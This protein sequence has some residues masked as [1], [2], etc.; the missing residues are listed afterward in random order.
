MTIEIKFRITDPGIFWS[1]QT[2]D[3]LGDYTL[4]APHIEEINDTY[5]DSKKRK[6]LA[7]GYRCRRREQGKG[8]L[9]TLTKLGLGKGA[10]K[11][12]QKWEVSLKKNKNNPANWPKSTAR[13]RVLKIISDKK[14]QIIFEFDQT[15]ITRLISNGKHVIARANLDEV[16]LMLNGKE[17]HF[18]TLKL[19]LTTP[20]QKNHLNALIAALQT[21]W[22]LKTE[23]LSKFER[24]FA[25]EKSKTK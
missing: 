22:P 20:N 9:I 8:Y 15:R 5:L 6:L 3:H 18:K 19:K 17:H 2:I 13:S 16:S 1:L 25:M 12:Q 14:L 24:A 10:A 4:S 23:P 21:K 7:A 11:N